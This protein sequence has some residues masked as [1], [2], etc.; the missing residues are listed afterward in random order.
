MCR[1]DTK[2][3]TKAIP[4]II[5]FYWTLMKCELC[6]KQFNRIFTM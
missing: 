2:L 1:M 6:K 3:G 4:G 5:C